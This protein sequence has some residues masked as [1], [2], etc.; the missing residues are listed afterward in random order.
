V[1][2]RWRATV[3]LES[4]GRRRDNENFERYTYELS[5][6]KGSLNACNKQEGSTRAKNR[7][8]PTRIGPQHQQSLRPNQI[9]NTAR[10]LRRLLPD[11]DFLQISKDLGFLDT[12]DRGNFARYRRNLPFPFLIQEI[13]TLTYRTAL[14]G[15]PRTPMRIQIKSGRRYAVEVAVSTRLISVVLIRP[16]YR[17]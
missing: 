15:R 3:K 11:A 14:F 8:R 6:L 13:L 7:A 17:K 10:H 16:T 4:P 12:L 2:A 9:A 1:L 5:I